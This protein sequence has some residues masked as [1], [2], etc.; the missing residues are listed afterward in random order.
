MITSLV[1]N[2][3]L[4]VFLGRALALNF[5]VAG[6]QIFTP[7]LAVLDAPQ[8]GTPLGGGMFPPC[9]PRTGSLQFYVT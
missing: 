5:T 8:P 9:C 7:G 1:P 4:L 3:L 6:G 2:A